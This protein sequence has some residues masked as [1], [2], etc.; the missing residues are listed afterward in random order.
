MKNKKHLIYSAVYGLLMKNNKIF[1]MRRFNTGYKDGFFT[2][3]AGHIEKDE[4]PKEAM[5]R[6]LKEETGLV[7]NIESIIPI[8]VM[9]RI[10]DSGR[11]YVDYY[12]KIQKY[13]NKPEKKETRKCDYIDWYSIENIPNNTLPNV[14]IALNFIKKKILISE[15]RE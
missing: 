10:C 6:E 2:F 8:H 11:T 14:K 7:C 12:F 15:K 3:P 9:H 13:N 1:L 4:L 5:L